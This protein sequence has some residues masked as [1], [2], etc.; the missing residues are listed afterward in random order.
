MERVADHFVL[1]EGILGDIDEIN[2][3]MSYNALTLNVHHPSTRSHTP[4]EE[5]AAHKITMKFQSK[6]MK[7][8]KD[9]SQNLNFQFPP[10]VTIQLLD[11]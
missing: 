9:K 7:C 5:T 8:L 1:F 3:Q 11:R 10:T 6:L 4:V 2:E